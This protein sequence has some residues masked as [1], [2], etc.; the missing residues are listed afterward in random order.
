MGMLT[1]LVNSGV[2][3][4]GEMLKSALPAGCFRVETAEPG[5]S[6]LEAAGRTRPDIAVIDFSGGRGRTAELESDLLR[7][8]RPD[9]RI[10]PVGRSPAGPVAD[11]ERWIRWSLAGKAASRI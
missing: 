7:A 6:F 3:G 11:I 9:V 4:F 2:R 1:I 5:R 8:I 10:I